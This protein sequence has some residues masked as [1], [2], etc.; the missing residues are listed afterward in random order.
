[1]GDPGTRGRGE[2][3]PTDAV[4][5]GVEQR[6]RRAAQRRRLPGVR[7]HVRQRTT[8]AEAGNGA[9]VPPVLGPPVEDRPPHERRTKVA[10]GRLGDREARC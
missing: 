7:H 1:M 4:G 2:Q 5:G 10:M 6:V 9:A 8:R 3:H